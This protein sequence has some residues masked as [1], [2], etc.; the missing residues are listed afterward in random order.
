MPGRARRLLHAVFRQNFGCTH[1]VVGRDHAGVG[2]YYGPFD[3]H[4]IFDT[5]PP[6]SMEIQPLKIDVTFFCY[7]CNGMAT[8]KTCPHGDADR[9]AISGTRLREMF[10]ARRTDPGGIQ[11]PEVVEVCRPITTVSAERRPPAGRNGDHRMIIAQ[12][13]DT[14][15][16]AK[17]SEQP[18]AASRAESLR[19]CVANIN[20]QR[21]DAVIHTGDSVHEGRAEEYAHLREILADLEAPLFLVPG[22]RDRREAL[23][24]AFGDVAN[25]P[26]DGEFLHYAVED[27]PLRLIALD[28][29]AAG[30]RKGAFCA[31][32]A[33]WL[34]ETLAR[35]A[36]QAG[37]SFPPPSAVRYPRTRLC[38]RLP[39]AGGRLG[40]GGR[41]EAPS[42][43]RRV[44]CGHVHCLHSDAWAGTVATVMPSVAVDLRIGKG[45]S[46]TPSYLLHAVSEDCGIVTRTRI[47]RH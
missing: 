16:L 27:F 25:L 44:L 2:D 19:R 29:V 18:T 30:E 38:R 9:L 8:G 35:R 41:G 40:T 17:S 12:I 34:D 32:R 21:V 7:K 23:R 24:G 14:H 42:Q 11:P 36:G 45:A 20:R 22:N 13:S 5:L 33:A 3:A 28:T 37:D 1:L 47:A 15:I 6:G 43:V 39:K 31:E 26:A 4:H 46:T 10:A